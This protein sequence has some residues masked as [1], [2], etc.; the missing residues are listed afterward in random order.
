MIRLFAF[1]LAFFLLIVPAAATD[2]S[3]SEDP[4]GDY[5]ESDEGYQSSLPVDD[6]GEDLEVIESDIIIP[7]SISVETVELEYS[8]AAEEALLQVYSI[9]DNVQYGAYFYADITDFGESYIYIP[10][11]YS[12]DCFS[13]NA[14]GIPINITQSTIT[15]YVSGSSSN[16]AI[17]FPSFG[18]PRYREGTGY[19]YSYI[20]DWEEINS[21]VSVFSNEDNFSSYSEIYYLRIISFILVIDVF[22]NFLIRLLGGMSR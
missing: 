5:V 20:T 17:Q 6:D 8:G 2:A 14:D 3:S 4:T 1:F 22:V 11:I 9:A 10:V 12:S 16:L 15:G 21:T 7:D 18:L 19:D 13:Y